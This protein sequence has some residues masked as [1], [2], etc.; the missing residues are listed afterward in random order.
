MG[1]IDHGRYGMPVLH[2]PDSR[3]GKPG[4]IRNE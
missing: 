3:L 1:E 2:A 4:I